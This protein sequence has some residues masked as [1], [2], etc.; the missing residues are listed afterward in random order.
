MVFF[1]K[2]LGPS[3]CP[4]YCQSLDLAGYIALCYVILM[5][6]SVCC[7]NAQRGLRAILCVLCLGVRYL[8]RS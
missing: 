2:F 1:V 5:I 7:F 3:T 4:K 8:L 6:V